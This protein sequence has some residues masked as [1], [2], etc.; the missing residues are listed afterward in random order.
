MK[1]ESVACGQFVPGAE[2]NGEFIGLNPLPDNTF[3]PTLKDD[4]FAEFP[5]FILPARNGKINNFLRRDKPKLIIVL[6][7]APDKTEY[8]W[9]LLPKLPAYYFKTQNYALYSTYEQIIYTKDTKIP[10]TTNTNQ[11][12]E[13]IET[14]LLKSEIYSI[15]PQCVEQNGKYLLKTGG[16]LIISNLLLYN[17]LESSSSL[18]NSKCLICRTQYLDY[19]LLPLITSNPTAFTFYDP[20]QKV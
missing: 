12:W 10:Q 15:Q 8:C 7:V 9:Y 13:W 1:F 5:P 11:I 2:E 4:A 20:I 3:V 14:T 16:N 19:T 18:N 17:E 6:T